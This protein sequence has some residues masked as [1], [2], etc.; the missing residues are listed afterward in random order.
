MSVQTH[1][2]TQLQDFAAL[3]ARAI[4]RKHRKDA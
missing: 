2:E 3:I 4:T 1:G